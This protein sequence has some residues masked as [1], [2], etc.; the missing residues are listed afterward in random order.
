MKTTLSPVLI[1]PEGGRLVFAR[2]RL[3]RALVKGSLGLIIHSNSAIYRR[4][5]ICIYTTETAPYESMHIYEIRGC[6]FLK[7]VR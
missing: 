1:G 6:I 7:L 4:C 3:L 2:S 5:N